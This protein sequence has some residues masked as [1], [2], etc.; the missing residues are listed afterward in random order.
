MH[1]C[2]QRVSWQQ[3]TSIQRFLFQLGYQQIYNYRKYGIIAKMS[4]VF[5]IL[6]AS[7]NFGFPGT[8]SAPCYE[9]KRMQLLIVKSQLYRKRNYR[10]NSQCGK[11]LLYVFIAKMVEMFHLE[12]DFCDVTVHKLCYAYHF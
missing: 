3:R 10:K 4:I 11:S 12:G 7:H 1:T 6:K 2:T 9:E 5:R 8:L